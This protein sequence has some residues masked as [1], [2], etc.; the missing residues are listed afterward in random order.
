MLKPLDGCRIIDF[1]IITAGAGTSALLADLGA[2]VIKVESPTYQDPFR[3]WPFANGA[4]QDAVSPFFRSNN[5][6][7]RAISIDL[8]RD[9][10]REAVLRLV[11]RSDVVLENFRR[12]V[13][14]RLGLGATAL[15]AANPDIILLSISSQGLT[16]P[17]AGQ[18]SFGSTLEAVG[19]LAWVTGYEGGGPV[20]SGRDLNYPDQVVALFAAGAVLAAW[21]AR[22]RGGRGAV[23]DVS[24][25]ELTSF[26]LGEKFLSVAAAPE[27]GVRLGNSEPPFLLQDC[28]KASDGRWIAVSIGPDELP[29]LEAC[30][31]NSAPVP[32]NGLGKA[33]GEWIGTGTQ[34]ERLAALSAAGIAAAPVRDGADIARPDPRFPAAGLL[35][36]QDGA[37]VKGYP[38]RL[39]EAM[40]A[41]T[42]E[43]PA[44]GADTAEILRTIAGYDEDA[45]AGLEARGII[46]CAAAAV[47]AEPRCSPPLR[48][49]TIRETR[50]VSSHGPSPA[51]R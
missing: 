20:V 30:L 27:I 29:A 35:G 19:G 21:L 22:K 9:E 17:D 37:L 32:G 43:A 25:R 5:R 46:Q 14:D 51:D 31:G 24:Q 1:G 40:H 50:P 12:G 10:G 33:L 34:A 7:K 38:F 16:G 8:K 36:T 4:G 48:S 28:F 41:A 2:E 11:A 3:A 23:L 39:D 45:I 6:G 47:S 18:V 42:G 44:I 26:M 15:R 49:A 13:L